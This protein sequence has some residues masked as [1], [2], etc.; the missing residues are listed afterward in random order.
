MRFLRPSDIVNE[1]SLT[2]VG[3]STHLTVTELAGRLEW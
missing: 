2:M 1:D 3:E